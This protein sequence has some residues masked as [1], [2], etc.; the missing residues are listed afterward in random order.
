MSAKRETHHRVRDASFRPDRCKVA[1]DCGFEVECREGSYSENAKGVA[2]GFR[3]HRFGG[4]RDAE[5]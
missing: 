2:E 5:G 1:C 4:N 3:V